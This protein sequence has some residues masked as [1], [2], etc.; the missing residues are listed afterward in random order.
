MSKR[1]DRMRDLLVAAFKP[2]RLEI[3]DESRKHASHAA[4]SGLEA[5]ETHYRVLM[6]SPALA[7]LSRVARSRAVHEALAAEF[8]TGLHALSLILR[9]PEEVQD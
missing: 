5:G 9:T 8:T 6:V 3:L 7:G 1:D 2:V 4:R